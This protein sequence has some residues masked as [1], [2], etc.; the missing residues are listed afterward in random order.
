VSVQLGVSQPNVV[1]PFS[2]YVTPSQR[3]LVSRRQLLE[4]NVCSD[5]K[6]WLSGT[7]E[8]LLLSASCV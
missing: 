6:P 3:R 5:F 8:V 1:T 7:S 2:V 4:C